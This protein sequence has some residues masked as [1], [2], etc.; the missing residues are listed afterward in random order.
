LQAD[1]Q[2]VG[3]AI[4]AR[5]AV[6]PHDKVHAVAEGRLRSSHDRTLGYNR[7]VAQLNILCGPRF[8]RRSA[9]RRQR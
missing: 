1:G 8:D 6:A 5:P 3:G 4:E 7:R 2:D 9:D